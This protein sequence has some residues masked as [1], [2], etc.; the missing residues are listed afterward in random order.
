MTS[1][2]AHI[3]SLPKGTLKVGADA[4]VTVFDPEA[5]FTIDKNKFQSKSRNT[6]FHGWDVQGR[7]LYTIVKGK[8]VFSSK[9][10]IQ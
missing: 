3:L 1:H 8:V 9:G 2:P 6:P 4:D 7:V 10:G 5:K